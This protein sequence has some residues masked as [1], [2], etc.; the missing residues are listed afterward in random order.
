[1]IQSQSSVHLGTLG[2]INSTNQP[3]RNGV[4][5]ASKGKLIYFRHM[6]MKYLIFFFHGP[7]LRARATVQPTHTDLLSIQHLYPVNNVTVGSHPLVVRL[8]KGIYHL[9]TP[10]PR[11]S[12]T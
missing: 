11:Y 9:R 1:M 4:A 5:G 8:L 10:F 3:G 2:L 12:S 6:S 7:L